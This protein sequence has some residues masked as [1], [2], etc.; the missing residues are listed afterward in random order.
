MC[1]RD[2]IYRLS[3]DEDVPNGITIQEACAFAKMAQDAGADAIHVSAGTWDSRLHNYN[4]VMA[5]KKS[6]EGLNLSRGVATSM[7]VPPN[8]TPRASLEMCIR[9]SR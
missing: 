8:Y 3:A 2:R 4:D 6:P 9:D 1:I 5:G 7:W